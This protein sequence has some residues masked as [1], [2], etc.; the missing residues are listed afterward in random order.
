MLLVSACGG[1]QKPE[2]KGEGRVVLRGYLESGYAE[3]DHYGAYS[4]VL[5]PRQPGSDPRYIE[6]LKAYTS[7]PMAPILL[8]EDARR[9]QMR[10]IT[11]VPVREVAAPD[12]AETEWIVHEYDV[13]RATLILHTQGLHGIGPYILTSNTPLSVE[14]SRVSLAVLDLSQAPKESMRAWLEVFLK[15][16]QEPEDWLQRRAEYMIVKLQDS[17][18]TLYAGTQVTVESIEPARK[19]MTVVG[20]SP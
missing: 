11:Y 10:N 6:L 9:L 16:S 5:I 17:L 1:A 14:S 3:R 2:M 8:D 19:I 20:L 18:A 13:T 12:A 7:L 15:R 4:Y